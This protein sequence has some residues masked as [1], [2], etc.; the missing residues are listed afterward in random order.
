MLDMDHFK[1]MNDRYGHQTGDRVLI[2]IS[3]R[4][5]EG[6]PST[7]VVARWGGEEFVILLRSCGLDDG[8]ATGEKL[9]GQ[10]ADI[11]LVDVGQ[12]TVSIG[13]AELQHDDT[14]DSW[15]ARAD[16]ALYKAKRSGRNAVRS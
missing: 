16:E 7:D 2:E 3:R 15:L 8:L 12:V 4:L 5:Q 11:V 1:S 10:I 6:L 13:A 9:R 14:L